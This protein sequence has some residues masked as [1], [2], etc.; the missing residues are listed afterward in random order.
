MV[1]HHHVHTQAGG[2]LDFFHSSDAGI[3]RNHQLA[4]SLRQPPDGGLVESIAFAEPIWNIINAVRPLR[5]EILH[6]QGGAGDAVHI[7]IAIDG[8]FVAG[9]Q[10]PPHFRYGLV[11]IRQQERVSQAVQRGVQKILGLPAPEP[12]GG[13]SRSRQRGKTQ[14]P[15]EQRRLFGLGLGD[16]PQFLFHRVSPKSFW[17]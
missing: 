4:A 9:G 2:I 12:S 15:L 10:R 11:H 3:H 16:F 17:A 5:T 14:L 7:V 1:R 13:Q 6:Q 8:D